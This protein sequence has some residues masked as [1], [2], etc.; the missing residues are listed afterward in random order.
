M[1]QVF[2]MVFSRE[3]SPCQ[4][5]IY[6][7]VYNSLMAKMLLDWGT[8]IFYFTFLTIYVAEVNLHHRLNLQP[9]LQVNYSISCVLLSLQAPWN[10]NLMHCNEKK[11]R[12]WLKGYVEWELDYLKYSGRCFSVQKT[13]NLKWSLGG[14]RILDK[15]HIL[16]S[17]WS[18]KGQQIKLARLREGFYLFIYLLW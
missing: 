17:L 13:S 11:S 4:V 18:C 9:N 16:I 7:N 10:V 8:F 3:I 1:L 6:G 15:R 5:H 2:K 12:A 14:W